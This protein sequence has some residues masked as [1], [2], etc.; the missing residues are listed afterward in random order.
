MSFSF[1]F[2]RGLD[3]RTTF[4]QSMSY[5]SHMGLSVSKVLWSVPKKVIQS[6]RQVT[7]AGKRVCSQLAPELKVP[8]ISTDKQMSWWLSAVA[9]SRPRLW[10]VDLKQATFAKW[11][12]IEPKISKK[13]GNN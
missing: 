1:I 5:H 11:L 12:D 6:L 10:H 9:Y 2:L 3:V 13:S 8:Y 4:A 7:L